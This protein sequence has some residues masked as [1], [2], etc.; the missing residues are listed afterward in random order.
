MHDNSNVRL[1]RENP[2]VRPLE[3]AR[4]VAGGEEQLA[5]A[6]RISTYTLSRWLSGEEAPPMKSY[7]AAIHFAGRSSLRS[8]A[9]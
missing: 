1:M 6:L 7:M 9:A 5:D 3:N 2:Y 8:R 4:R